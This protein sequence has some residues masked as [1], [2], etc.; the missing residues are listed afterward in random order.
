MADPFHSESSSLGSTS[1]SWPTGTSERRS[2]RGLLFA[3]P[4]PPPDGPGVAPTNRRRPAVEGEGHRS[5]LAFPAGFG[6]DEAMR[7]VARLGKP[8]RGTLA[9][10]RHRGANAVPVPAG[11][12]QRNR[13]PGRGVSRSR[14][15]ESAPSRR[16]KFAG[17]GSSELA[18]RSRVYR[19]GGPPGTTA[20]PSK[21]RA[22]GR[23]QILARLQHT[24]IAQFTPFD[25]PTSGLHPVHALFQQGQPRG[26]VGGCRRW[27]GRPEH[28]GHSLI[29]PRPDQ[30]EPP[31]IP[32]R[33]DSS[34]AFVRSASRPAPRPAGPTETCSAKSISPS[35]SPAS[36]RYSRLVRTGTT[37]VG[38]ADPS[39]PDQHQ[40]S[41]LFLRR[42]ARS[43]R[44][45]I[46]ARLAEGSTMPTR[47]D[48]STAT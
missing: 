32:S 4:R 5:S 7:L 28:A 27:A 48:C 20:G 36:G 44:S 10:R 21:T 31:A 38:P 6:Q 13:K 41:R 15:R 45:L 33:D 14:S 22:G 23:A 17:F 8:G 39:Q 16:A 42:P 25:D 1:T 37:T 18:A 24:R 26:G 2:F 47:Q 40:P 9:R 46:V 35:P 19:G 43:G 11:T 29:E 34:S 30:S 12:T 3:R